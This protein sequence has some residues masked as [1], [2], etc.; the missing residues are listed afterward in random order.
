MPPPNGAR[1][2][3]NLKG[4]FCAFNIFFF[5]Q[6][7]NT[8]VARAASSCRGLPGVDGGLIGRPSAVT[9]SLAL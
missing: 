7:Q 4:S 6:Q 1:V 3:G 8:E 9:I 5:T 2:D